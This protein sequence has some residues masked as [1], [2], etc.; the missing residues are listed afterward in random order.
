[1]SLA[2]CR[3]CGRLFNQVIDKN[4]CPSCLEKEEEEFQRVKD[5]FLHH[6]QASIVEAAQETGVEKK[7][8]LQFVREGRLRI[9]NMEEGGEPLFRCERCGKPIPEGRYCEEC[10]KK[11]AEL[12]SNQD[13]VKPVNE[14]EYQRGNF[15]FKEKILRKK[16]E[17]D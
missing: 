13:K 4:I 15:Y 1:M 7:F 14:R 3:R 16:E 2:K 10:R 9:A 8:I 11:I 17:K 12:L 5:F 6:P